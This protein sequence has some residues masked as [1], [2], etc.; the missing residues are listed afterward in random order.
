MRALWKCHPSRWFLLL[1][2]RSG[3]QILREMG[4]NL[5][6]LSL[7]FADRGKDFVVGATKRKDVSFFKRGTTEA[8]LKLGSPGNDVIDR[9][10][11]DLKKRKPGM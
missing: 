4:V 8:K 2:V 10:W 7:A 5:A 11:E 9:T 6:A 1:E 3:V